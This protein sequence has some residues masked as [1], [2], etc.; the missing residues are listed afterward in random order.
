MKNNLIDELVRDLTEVTPR[1]KSE[2]RRRIKAIREETIEAVKKLITAE[3][4]IA[5]FEGTQTSRLT[6][7]WNKVHNLK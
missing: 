5:Q 2:V 7:L 4:L 3:I 6:S 1:P